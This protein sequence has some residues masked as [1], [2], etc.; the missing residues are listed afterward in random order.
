MKVSNFKS[1]DVIRHEKGTGALYNHMS[2]GKPRPFIMFRKGEPRPNEAFSINYSYKETHKEVSEFAYGLYIDPNDDCSDAD[3]DKEVWSIWEEGYG[4]TSSVD[5][6][7]KVPRQ[8]QTKVKADE[9]F[10]PHSY[11]KKFSVRKY[12]LSKESSPSSEERIY[13]IWMD[14]YGWDNSQN[15]QGNK[16]ISCLLYTSDAADDLL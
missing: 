7:G 6:D 11:D 3:D 14:G 8:L 15:V 2:W 13:A 9:R 10:H 4:W 16:P 1:L 5:L 12:L